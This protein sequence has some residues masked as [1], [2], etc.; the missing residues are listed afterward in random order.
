MTYDELKAWDGGRPPKAQR[1]W[2]NVMRQ[3]AEKLDALPVR[4]ARG[5]RR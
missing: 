1:R 4:R 5:P 2:D 3:L